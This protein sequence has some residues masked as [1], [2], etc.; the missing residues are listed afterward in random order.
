MTRRHVV[1]VVAI[2]LALGGVAAAVW[3]YGAARYADGRASVTA[4]TTVDDGARVTAGALADAARDTV[5]TV[6]VRVTHTKWRVETLLVSVPDSLREVPEIAE[7]VRVTG[8][9]TKQVDTLTHA[10]DMAQATATMRAAVDEA[11]LV[12]AR[13][14]TRAQADTIRTLNRRPTW[15]RALTWTAT[16]T[17]AAFVAGVRH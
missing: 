3:Q 16:A 5:D 8:L 9:L 17:A 14:V 12:A 2:L 6:L 10:L 1:L 13:R 4:T 11:A 7:L 15:R